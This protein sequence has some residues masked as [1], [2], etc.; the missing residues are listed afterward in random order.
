M[1]CKGTV[2]QFEVSTVEGE[3]VSR[4]QRCLCDGYSWG[5]MNDKFIETA[6]VTDTL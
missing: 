4:E 5:W 1:D 6:G 3:A 2:H